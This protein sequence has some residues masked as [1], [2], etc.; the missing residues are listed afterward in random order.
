MPGCDIRISQSQYKWELVLREVKCDINTVQP[1]PVMG[2]HNTTGWILLET[3]QHSTSPHLT[4]L[5]NMDLQEDNLPPAA[6]TDREDK[7]D[8]EDQAGANNNSLPAQVS[9]DELELLK[10]LEEANRWGWWCSRVS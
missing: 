1:A 4:H 5:T 2:R 6:F 7:E 9:V 10:K 8:K 3:F